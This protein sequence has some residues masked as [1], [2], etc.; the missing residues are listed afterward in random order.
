MPSKAKVYGFLKDVN[1]NPVEG[2]KI[3]ATLNGS[4]TWPDGSRL[5]TTQ[6]DATSDAS[7]RWEVDLVVN[8][9]GRHGSTTWTIKA[10]DPKVKDLFTESNL[11]VAAPSEISMDMLVITSP[12]NIKTAKEAA[13]VRV[14]PV[15]NYQQYADMPNKKPND[16]VAV[17][18]PE[19]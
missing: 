12:V 19:V 5:T 13:I 14:V 4:D 11:F 10:Y 16:I 18:T 2:G 17:V 15:L 9:E 1:G 6:V 7:G 3:V 8:A